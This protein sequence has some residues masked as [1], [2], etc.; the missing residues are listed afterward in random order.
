MNECDLTMLASVINDVERTSIGDPWRG[1]YHL[2]IKVD[3]MEEADSLKAALSRLGV[4]SRTNVGWDPAGEPDRIR[5][6]VYEQPSLACLL[7]ILGDHLD[8]R[9]RES[10]D[11][12]VR[13]RGPIPPKI[14]DRIWS[15]K[16][17][18]CLSEPDIAARMNKKRIADGMGGK[19]W[20]AAKVKKALASVG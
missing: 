7:E 14:L 4:A 6:A 19:G 8:T 13:A 1:T 15:L 18:H 11:Q 5:L 12:L 17:N 3:T 9:P 10:L 16:H 2:N 20:S